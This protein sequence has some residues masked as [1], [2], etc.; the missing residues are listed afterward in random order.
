MRRLLWVV[1]AVGICAR[2]AGA[3]NRDPALP[4]APLKSGEA[5]LFVDDYLIAWQSGLRRTLRQPVKDQGG[6]EPVLAIEDEFGETK[7]TLEANGTIV[8]DTRQKKWVMYSL[9]FASSWPGESADRVRLYRFT[10]DDAMHWVKGD[11]GKPQRIA[12]D[13][14]DPASKKNATNVDLFSS[15]YDEKDAENPY[16]GWLFFANWGE[17]REERTTS[18][19]RTAFADAGG[20]NPGGGS[21]TIEQDGRS[22]NGTGD[23]T[24]FYRDPETGRFLA[25]LRWASVTEIENSNRLRSRGFLFF[26]R[27]DSNR[28]ATGLAAEPDP[29]RGRTQRRHADGRILLFDGL[30]VWLVVAGRTADL[31]QQ[32]RLSLL[33]QRRRV[34][35][36]GRQPRRAELEESSFKNEEG[37]PEVFIPTDRKEA[38][39]S[40]TTAG[41]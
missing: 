41:T 24:T 36:A 21:R 4:A 22:M 29:R 17:G 16:K 20:K 7:A 26:D 39:A 40:A 12:I 13:L 35:E 31:A 32:G 8:Y 37:I 2:G 14:H 34:H 30:E 6:N 28:L 1:I 25:C 33:R 23:V 27:L 11:D 9:A 10:S 19:R 5:Q 3:Q 38:T 18:I 15:A